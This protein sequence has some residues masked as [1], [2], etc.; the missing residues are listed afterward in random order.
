MSIRNKNKLLETTKILKGELCIMQ[1]SKKAVLSCYKQSNYDSYKPKLVFSRSILTDIQLNILV[2][3]LKTEEKYAIQITE[4]RYVSFLDCICYENQENIVIRKIKEFQESMCQ[5]IAD[6][7]K[8]QWLV[9]TSVD[10]YD[11]G[12]YSDES[13][14]ISDFEEPYTSTVVAS[15]LGAGSGLEVFL[16]LLKIDWSTIFAGTIVNITAAHIINYF[17]D[18]GIE[19][20]TGRKIFSINKEKIYKEFS[21]L[22]STDPTYMEIVNIH[23]LNDG[24]IELL[25]RTFGNQTYVVVC[26]PEFSVMGFR[27]KEL[28]E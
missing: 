28:F 14:Y 1:A 6:E 18:K 21:K 24:N 19:W 16:N 12:T 11:D 13:K 26:S 8:P 4:G 10:A 25:I 20:P 27:K 15:N 2:D 23:N 17:K 7:E 22:I 3:E 5:S 9:L